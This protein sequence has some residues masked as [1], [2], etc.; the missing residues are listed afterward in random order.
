MLTFATGQLA[1]YAGLVLAALPVAPAAQ[2]AAKLDAVIE[3]RW[4]E[5]KVTPVPVADD[6]TFLRRAY[7]DLTGQVPPV[8]TVQAF[9]ADKKP[10]KHGRLVD[11]LLASDAFAEHWARTWVVRL[12]DRRPVPLD[13]HNGK[14][15]Q[16]YLRDAI[17]ANKPY[18]KVVRE[19]ITGDGLADASGPANFYLRYNADPIQIAGAVGKQFMGAT[20]QCA[21]CHDHIFAK[22]KKSDFWGMAAA[23]GRLKKVTTEDG[24]VNGVLEA[25]RGDLEQPDPKGKPNED[26]TVPMLVMKPKLP[27]G[28]EPIKGKRRTVLADWLTADDNPYLA[29][30]F[31]NQTWK[32]VFGGKLIAGL[33][34]L[35][36]IPNALHGDV[37]EL[38]TADFKAGGYDVKRLVRVVVLTR[39]YQLGSKGGQGSA[40]DVKLAAHQVENFA[41]FRTR[42]LSVDEL[43]ASVVASTGWT[44]PAPADGQ[45]PPPPPVAAAKPPEMPEDPEDDPADKPVDALGPNAQ[46]VQRALVLLNGDFI[47]QAVT[48]GAALA[49]KKKGAAVGAAHVEYLFLATL[50]RKPDAAES[51]AM[52]KLLDVED[53]NGGLQDVV[54]ALI[55]TAEFNSNH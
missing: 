28:S 26:G 37:L 14:V 3:A 33:D 55:N 50:S 29:R 21:Q 15:L 4:K 53:K 38:L 30:H 25:R 39:A 52:L 8:E 46:T 17:K 49:S 45:P 54:W 51:A 43:Y 20:L 5:E 7:L 47:N 12:T 13:T 18:P 19:I 41:R 22:W 36:A 10:D 42:P 31:V 11:E 35:D 16:E 6:A 9:L 23:F 32:E 40:D 2:V 1:V 48:A 34:D 44:P 27:G 24:T